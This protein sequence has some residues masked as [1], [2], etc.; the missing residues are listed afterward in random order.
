MYLVVGDIH[1][2]T[3]PDDSVQAYGVEA[4]LR[5]GSQHGRMLSAS[6]NTVLRSSHGSQIDDLV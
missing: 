4:V 2:G 5:P 3:V 1:F 6:W